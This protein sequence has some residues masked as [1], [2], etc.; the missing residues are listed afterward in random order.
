MISSSGV[1]ERGMIKIR[2]DHW[3][4]GSDSFRDTVHYNFIHRSNPGRYLYGDQRTRSLHRESYWM[5]LE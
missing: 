3:N 2:G 5:I 4:I 1:I